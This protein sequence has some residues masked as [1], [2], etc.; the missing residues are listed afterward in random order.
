MMTGHYVKLDPITQGH[1]SCSGLTGPGFSRV[2]P[3]SPRIGTRQVPPGHSVCWYISRQVI[4]I[5][6]AALSFCVGVLDY[7]LLLLLCAHG[8]H[9]LAVTVRNTMFGAASSVCLVL[10]SVK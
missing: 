9:W 4:C 3:H 7:S 2:P 10:F 6:G 5:R 1:V 8:G